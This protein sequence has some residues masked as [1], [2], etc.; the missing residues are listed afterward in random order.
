MSLV[1]F[2]VLNSQRVLLLL[3]FFFP[4]SNYLSNSIKYS[5]SKL[6]ITVLFS[7]NV[8]NRSGTGKMVK[9]VEKTILLKRLAIG[10]SLLFTA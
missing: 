4:L 7:P 9:Y 2:L 3:I 8:F 5:F 10:H 6:R 1:S